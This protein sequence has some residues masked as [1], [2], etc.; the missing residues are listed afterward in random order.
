[1]NGWRNWI[2]RIFRGNAKSAYRTAQA[3]ETAFHEHEY[4]LAVRLYEDSLLRFREL[5]QWHPVLELRLR[6]G[7]L[8]R[9]LGDLATARTHYEQAI[10]LA[11]N[12]A[13]PQ[14]LGAALTGLASVAALQG[15]YALARRLCDECRQL[16][17]EP[18]NA[19][20]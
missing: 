19:L 10:S 1:M 15:E 4:E 20:E 16:W 3:A 8:K 13:L 9:L 14:H 12:Q 5:E 18:E 17:S 7:Y 11:R 2:R 6:L